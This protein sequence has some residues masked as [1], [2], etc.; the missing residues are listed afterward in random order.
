MKDKDIQDLLYDVATWMLSAN[1]GAHLVHDF[2][3]L[4]KLPDFL[5][6]WRAHGRKLHDFELQLYTSLASTVKNQMA[7]GETP[8]C[9]MRCM[10]GD[11]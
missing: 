2:P 3:F 6:P 10:S 7:K 4:D 9:I 8:E 11:P 5:A 1:P